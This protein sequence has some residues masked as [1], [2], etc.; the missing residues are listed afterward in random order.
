MNYLYGSHDKI[1]IEVIFFPDLRNYP[2][3]SND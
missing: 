2:Y 1:G 3:G